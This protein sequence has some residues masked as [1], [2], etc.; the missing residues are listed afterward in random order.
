LIEETIR[1][2]RRPE[3]LCPLADILCDS[4]LLGSI[5]KGATILEI[6]PVP[7]APF[8]D[9]SFDE[10]IAK[11]Y[12]LN[13]SSSCDNMYRSGSPPFGRFGSHRPAHEL[14]ETIRKSIKVLEK[15]LSGLDIL[16][17]KAKQ[18]NPRPVMGV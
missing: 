15:R 8:G 10:M 18:K 13:V 12:S 14:K 17:F 4:L 16:D 6:L 9:I 3:I 2:Y 5:Q 1:R 7:K 11:L